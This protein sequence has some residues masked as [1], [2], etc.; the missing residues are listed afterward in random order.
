MEWWNRL[1]LMGKLFAPQILV[2]FVCFLIIVTAGLGFNEAQTRLT[3]IMDNDV[4][5]TLLIADAKVYLPLIGASQKDVLL[6]P[7]EMSFNNKKDTYNQN[8]KELRTQLSHLGSII[9]KPERKKLV[10][11]IAND[12]ETYLGYCDKSIAL[13]HAG[14]TTE[15]MRISAE[16]AAQTRL[17]INGLI[18]NLLDSYK[19]DMTSNKED[20]ERD[21][22]NMKVIHALI[23]LLGLGLSYYILFRIVQRVIKQRHDEMIELAN[24]FETNV[25]NIVL[26]VGKK[27]SEMKESSDTLMNTSQEANKLSENVAAAAEQT[28]ANI[29]TV[30]SAT[31][32]LTSSISEISRQVADSTNITQRAV[33]QAQ[34]TSLTVKNLAETAQKIGEVVGLINEIANQTNLLAL[35]ATIEAARAGEAGK[36]FA[37]VA[38]EVKTLAGQTSKATEEIATQIASVQNQTKATVESISKIEETIVG[39]NQVTTRIAS[40]VEEQGA[41]TQEISRNLTEATMGSKDVSQNVSK[42]SRSSEEVGVVA[43]QVQVTADALTGQSQTLT[44][45]V[46]AFLDKVRAQ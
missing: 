23:A 5:K 6:A 13:H 35:N 19:E 25:N 43:V 21:T 20:L 1:G 14:N 38:S 28:A 42:V 32:E 40:A 2:V 22:R 27:A 45:R 16:E 41:A 30:A 34:D 17:H 9:K 44:E 33:N 29:Q 46:K 10:T 37:V 8:A 39:I 7:D 24:I 26:D 31:E 4:A 36:G 11:D 15:A 12:I 18:Q 3:R